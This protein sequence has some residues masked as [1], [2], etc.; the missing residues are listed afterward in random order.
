VGFD[1]FAQRLIGKPG[2]IELPSIG[3]EVKQGE[4]GFVVRRNGDVVQ[5]LCPI[6]GIVSNVNDKLINQPDLA[7]QS[8]YEKGWLCTIEP[9]KLGK[10]L[11][12]LYYGQEAVNFI[13]EE[14]EK[15][16]ALANE[17]LPV[18]ADGGTSVEDIFQELDKA[19]WK[20]C[21][22]VFLKT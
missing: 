19:A 17:D 8:P 9:V 12:G 7:N 20:K 2:R 11:K 21:I 13:G 3:Q 14:K 16:F 1:D 18:A 4:V 15:L 6:D 10:N 5:V 22:A